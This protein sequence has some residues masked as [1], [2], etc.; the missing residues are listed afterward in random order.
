LVRTTI[1][2]MARMAFFTAHPSAARMI[3][4]RRDW[5]KVRA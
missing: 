4:S 2:G 5:Q 1:S 3:G